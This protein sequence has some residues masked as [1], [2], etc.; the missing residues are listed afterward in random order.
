MKNTA[1]G[2][3]FFGLGYVVS[4]NALSMAFTLTAGLAFGWDLGGLLRTLFHMKR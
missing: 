4:D 1:I 2:W 3:V